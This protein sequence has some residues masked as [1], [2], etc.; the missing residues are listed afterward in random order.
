L[1]GS[2]VT[3]PCFLG[4]NNRA[5]RLPTLSFSF[6]PIWVGVSFSMAVNLRWRKLG[7]ERDRVEEGGKFPYDVTAREG[8][9][10]LII[11]KATAVAYTTMLITG[12]LLQEETQ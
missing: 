9:S 1:I 6:S 5:P 10:S 4:L 7:G 11:S 2:Y 3:D 8:S 12:G